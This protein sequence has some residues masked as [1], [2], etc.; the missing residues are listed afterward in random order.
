MIT[1]N[2]VYDYDIVNKTA[3]QHEVGFEI[4]KNIIFK[5][6]EIEDIDKIIETAS[7]YEIY[8]IVKVDYVISD[9]NELYAQLFKEAMSV[10]N[11]KKDLYISATG[12]KLH[13]TSKIFSEGFNIIYPNQLYQSYQAFE[14]SDVYGSYNSNYIKKDERKRNTFY[15]NKITASGY[16]KEINPSLT[17]VGVQATL[18]LKILFT[19]KK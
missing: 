7:K 16:D 19:I 12:I 18:D 13:P 8:D 5:L 14:S 11:I 2:L 1:Q 3:T 4:K 6:D 10:I 9:I 15:Y 17:K